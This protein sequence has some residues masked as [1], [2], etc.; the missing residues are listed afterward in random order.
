MWRELPVRPVRVDV[1]IAQQ[2]FFVRFF[3]HEGMLGPA[4]QNPWNFRKKLC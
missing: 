2:R 1:E 4:R 3:L